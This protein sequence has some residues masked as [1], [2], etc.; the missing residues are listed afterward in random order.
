MSL[1]S[2]LLLTRRDL[3]SHPIAPK[4]AQLGGSSQILGSML[5]PYSWSI[6]ASAMPAQSSSNGTPGESGVEL[7]RRASYPAHWRAVA[8]KVA[9][10]L[11]SDPADCSSYNVCVQMRL[12]FRHCL[13]SSRRFVF[14]N[15]MD[16]EHV[17]VLHR[18]WFRNLRVRVQRPDY[19]E[20]RLTG[21][22]YGLRQEVLARGGP[23]DADH[24]WY[25]FITAIARMRVEGSLDG[26]DGNLTQTE[27][28]TFN[29]AVLL[30][31]I[32]WLLRPLFVN[33]K[34]DILA[35]DTG[36]LEREYA[37][38]RGGFER[39]MSTPQ[40]VVVYGG[41]G[42]FGRI[43]VD[44]LL[45][46]TKAQ[47]EIASRTARSVKFPGYKS[48]VR[49]IES[50]LH[51]QDS[52]LRTVAGADLV[53]VAVGPFQGMP[54]TVLQAC[55]TK[56]IPYIDVADDC[57]FV[58]RAYALV[59]SQP[60]PHG[61][62]AMI[63]CSV[64]PGLTTL[65][66]RFAQASIP[67]IVQTKICISPGTQN[68]RGPGSFACLLSTVGKEFV[69]PAE[70]KPMSVIGWT[71]PEPVTFPA[72]MGHRTV[73]R[74]VDIADHFIQPLYFGTKT[75]EF[76]IGS[77]LHALNLLLS[78][79]RWV[80]QVFG[81]SMRLFIPISRA[82]IHVS[83]LVGS[84]AGGVMVEVAGFSGNERRRETW[85]V[86]A[87]VGGER[88][89]AMVPAIS[90]KMVLRGEIT[91]DGIVPLPVDSLPS[92]PPVGLKLSSAQKV[93]SGKLSTMGKCG[94]SEPRFSVI[95][96]CNR[97]TVEAGV[98]GI[99]FRASMRSLLACRGRAR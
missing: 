45:R 16:L 46:S 65:L 33:Q 86:F 38:D 56:R 83:A 92:S 20:Y 89:P 55:I 49:F 29:F 90:A 50:D 15:I 72:P 34:Q 85:C 25:E 31:P 84:T 41:N 58:R 96:R 30:A 70:G 19:V 75:V 1:H 32:F 26:E 67:D 12:T 11:P 27:V 17:C 98:V 54:L 79:V 87:G 44:E 91:G 48:R 63:G 28:I 64:V 10:F 82:L 78:A 95:C 36:L 68:P 69:A 18:R 35:A 40:R 42:F 9:R 2:R 93:E 5:R 6:P 88:I 43:I 80:R 21:M 3:G 53:I 60:T 99:S 13:R 71:K 8:Q 74:V 52:V 62:L 4:T 77:E 73:Y 81:I 94:R 57:D 51:N 66:T 47:I 14:E 39:T 97:F 24:Y 76:R 61:A 7:L 37:L 23:V 22:F 59:E